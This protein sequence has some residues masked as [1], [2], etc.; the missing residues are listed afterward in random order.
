MMQQP[1]QMNEGRLEMG[2]AAAAA[3]GSA[4]GA[5]VAT[6]SAGGNGNATSQNRQP[7][8]SGPKVGRNDPCWCG[9]GKK[10][11]RCHGA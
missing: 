4:A 5:A 10:F 8:R 11:K 6:A 9:S 7:A 3:G 1:R 2:G